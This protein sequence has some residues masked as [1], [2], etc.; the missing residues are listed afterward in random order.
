MQRNKA[1]TAINVLGLALGI[2]CSL[3]IFLWVSDEY[4]I[5]RFHQN[6]PQLYSVF[7]RQYHD[8]IVDAGHNTPGLLSQEM[9]N[10]FPEVEHATGFSWS[11]LG[12]F[13][14]NGKIIKES[15]NY[16]GEDF[17]KMFSYP[18]L[19]GRVAAALASPVSIAVSKKMA[20]DIF[21]SAENAFGKTLRFQNKKDFKITAVFDNVPANSSA[22]FDYLLNWET[23]LEYY[24]WAKDWG[25][26]APATYV[27]LRKGTDPREFA[28]KITAFLENYHKQDNFKIRLDLQ[29]YGD[30]YLHSNFKDGELAGGR[31]Q[32]VRLFSIVA[33]FILL[34]ACINFMNLSTARSARRAREIGVRK[35]MGAYRLALV[36]QFIGEAMLYVMLATV[37]SLIAVS[38][39]LPSF[40]ELTRK[41]IAIPFG[42]VRF[43]L[44][45]VAL[46]LLTGFLSGSYPALYLSSFRPVTVLK[47]SL[48]FG[49]A[50]RWSRKGLVVFQFV[51][52]IVLIIGTIVVS[53]QVN[54]IQTINLG[55]NREN[56]LYIPLEGE[57]SGKYGIFK[58]KA[59]ALPGIQAVT[60]ISKT[61]TNI[62][63]STGGVQW[64]GK[65]PTT[66]IQ[67]TPVG[68]G[69]DFIQTMKLAMVQGRDY[70]RDFATDSTGYIINETALQV[71]GFKDPIGKPLTFWQHPGRII[72]VVKDFHVNSLHEP[73]RPMILHLD[74]KMDDGIA[75][76]RTAPGETKEALT[77]LEQICKELNPKF[78]FTYQFSDEEYQ[79]LYKSEEIVG[80]LSKAFAF[81]AVFISC[82]G[83]LGLAMFTAEQRTREFGI[84]KVL[85]A[86]VASLFG[87]LSKEFVL[88]V[89]LALAI[90]SPLA[91]YFMNKWLLDYAYRVNLSWWMFALAGSAAVMIALLTV[92]FQA[93]KAAFVNPVK[94]LRTE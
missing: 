66:M 32:Y 8:G 42:D 48:K 59:L 73:I 3:L 30:M 7:E 92:S 39:V 69:Y 27:Q 67:F 90:A 72:G 37:V 81:L 49:T 13:E 36:R 22:K 56:L 1:F 79:K 78:P 91:W 47:G 70:A 35:V 4:S 61:P 54:F 31:I 65:A 85:G 2:A 38:F 11:E 23:F 68:V 16:A 45:M 34:I 94:S 17:F 10:V 75:L 18:L 46:L 50:A 51:L 21:G 12:T 52:S 14:A 57:L 20:E 71:I 76:V 83:L 55:Y 63:M 9:K 84:R 44:L 24:D 60:K 64:E 26:N 29:R 6:S 33:V 87:L 74:E 80:K 5:D 40:N 88:L 43:I 28:K 93:I 53:R 86:S 19:K 62:D 89:L 82:L 58:T 41:Q 25:N 15:G 77:S